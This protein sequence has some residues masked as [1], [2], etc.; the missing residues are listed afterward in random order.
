MTDENDNRDTINKELWCDL[1]QKNFENGLMFCPVC[2]MQIAN[3]TRQEEGWYC[4]FC[5]KKYSKP[6]NS[7][8]I[9]VEFIGYCPRCGQ[10]T[11]RLIC[12]PSAEFGVIHSE[13][14]LN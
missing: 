11:C 14:Q 10:N 1:C 6:R 8:T 2:G 12:L 4:Q 7:V 13:K 3:N 9:G 5:E